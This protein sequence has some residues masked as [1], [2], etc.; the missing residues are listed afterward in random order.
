MYDCDRSTHDR[1]RKREIRMISMSMGSWIR[2]HPW[3]TKYN[4]VFYEIFMATV[5][6]S[7]VPSSHL[8]YRH[9]LIVRSLNVALAR[10]VAL[11]TTRIRR[12]QVDQDRH[13]VA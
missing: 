3:E 4:R 12:P 10:D 8:Y 9:T 5:T 7:A 2:K 1:P 13:A 11:T 6:K